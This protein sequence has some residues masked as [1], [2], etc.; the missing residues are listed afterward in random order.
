MAK[1]IY[2]AFSDEYSDDFVTQCKGMKSLGIDY[3]EIR[4]ADGKSISEMKDPDLKEIKS[5]LDCYGLKISSIGS[6]LGKIKISDDFDSHLDLTKKICET[7][8]YLGTKNIRMFSFYPSP[9]TDI[10]S[11]RDDVLSRLEKMLDVASK[12][13]VYLCHENESDIYGE[14]GENCL[15]ILSYF[16]GRLKCVFD[17]GNLAFEEHDAY[18]AYNMLKDRIEYFHIKDGDKGVFLPSGY[19]KGHMKEILSDYKK[20]MTKDTFLTIEPHLFSFVGL[21]SITS[22]KLVQSIKFNNNEEAFTFAK[23]S[24]DKLLEEI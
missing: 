3:I 10:N 18:K 2:S 13:D 9:N 20:N 24:L 5:K 15:D 4:H 14:T 1:F 23:N 8:L 11:Q 12:Y 21:E 16:N 22:K 6:P 19:G 17:F 7:A